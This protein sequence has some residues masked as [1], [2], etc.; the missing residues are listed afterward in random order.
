[1]PA[2]TACAT[3]EF[4]DDGGTCGAVNDLRS[5]APLLRQSFA[6]TPTPPYETAMPYCRLQSSSVCW[7][8]TH[9]FLVVTAGGPFDGIDVG[10]DTRSETS[11][12][13]AI[14]TS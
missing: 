2:P 8:N 1:M 7:G 4:C 5:N 14:W 12:A 13:T 11:T 9:R 6:P 3:G 10:G